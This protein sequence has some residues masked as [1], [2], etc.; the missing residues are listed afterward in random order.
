MFN[1]PTSMTFEQFQEKHYK[2]Y[3]LLSSMRL[4]EWIYKYDMSDK[5]KE[6]HPSYIT[7]C[8]YLKTYTY[9]EA[10]QNMWNKWDKDERKLIMKLPNFDK[11]IFKE[12]TGIE[13]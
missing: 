3:T 9:K 11:E 13:V 12:I 8:G 10:C 5:E 1:K 7:T 6:E 2:A 4:T